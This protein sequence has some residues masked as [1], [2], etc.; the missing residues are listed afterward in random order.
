MAPAALEGAGV[1]WTPLSRLAH[2]TA[3]RVDLAHE[4]SLRRSADG[5]VARAVA[6]GVHIYRKYARLAA[7]PCACKTSPNTG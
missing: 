2:F 5:R 4:I 6:H 7:E 3:E 1:R